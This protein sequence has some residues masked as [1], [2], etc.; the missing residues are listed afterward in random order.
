M[1]DGPTLHEE[2]VRVVEEILQPAR[3]SPWPRLLSAA[4]PTAA[5]ADDQ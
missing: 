5:R 3:V 2:L 4:S 1:W